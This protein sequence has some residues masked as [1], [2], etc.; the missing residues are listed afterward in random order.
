MQGILIESLASGGEGPYDMIARW[1]HEP[2]LGL[3]NENEFRG[4]VRDSTAGN[5]AESQRLGL[6]R[7]IQPLTI[8]MQQ[9]ADIADLPILVKCEL[10]WNLYTA[11]LSRTN[12]ADAFNL[13]TASEE[14]WNDALARA[15]G[16]GDRAVAVSDSLRRNEQRSAFG[17][18]FPWL[19]LLVSLASFGAEQF[20]ESGRWRF[21]LLLT[22]AGALACALTGL[23][24]RYTTAPVRFTFAETGRTH[25]QTF[26]TGGREMFETTIGPTVL[27]VSSTTT[28]PPL[29]PTLPGNE[30]VLPT[31]Q[32]SSAVQGFSVG[33]EVSFTGDGEARAVLGQSGIVIEVDGDMCVVRLTSGLR[34]GPIGK[35]NLVRRVQV[36]APAETLQPQEPTPSTNVYAPFTQ[37]VS[38]ARVQSQAAR[39]KSALEK[40]SALQSTIPSWGQLFWQAVKNEDDL[41]GLEA[42]VKTTLISHGYFG[43]GTQSPPRTDELKKQLAQLETLGGPPHGTGGSV[44]RVVE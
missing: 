40:S 6:I 31:P 37:G 13:I 29:A 27:P 14:A 23:Y 21:Y 10:A 18:M 32:S 8:W 19:L 9:Q 34:I 17:E 4:R 39:L 26:E 20:V 11:A 36:T 12:G 25:Q 35:Q 38:E 41:Y 15:F 44:L 22:G 28:P 2:A 33:E 42:A 7:A 24:W 30:Q 43:P 3:P 5:D 16:Q 1:L